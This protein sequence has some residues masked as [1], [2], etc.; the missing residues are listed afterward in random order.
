MGLWKSLG[1][2][3]LVAISAPMWVPA[4]HRAGRPFVRGAIKGGVLLAGSV[5]EGVIRLRETA[6]DVSAEIQAEIE[7]ENDADAEAE[8]GAEPGRGRKT[9]Q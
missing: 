2:S 5:K 6:A 8:Q 9:R 1:P 3:L 7:A 4:I